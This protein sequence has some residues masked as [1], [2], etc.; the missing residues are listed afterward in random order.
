MVAL[1]TGIPRRGLGRPIEELAP[2]WLAQ[3]ESRLRARRGHARMRPEGAGPLH[4]LPLADR[5]I[6]TLFILRFTPGWQCST[7]CTCP[8]SPARWGDPAAA[9]RPLPAGRGFSLPGKPG[10]AAQPGRCVCPRRHQ[11]SE[12]VGSTA[13]R[14]RSAWTP[15]TR[16]WSGTSPSR[17]A[18]RRRNQARTPYP[19]KRP[20]GTSNATGSPPSGS[21]PGTPSPNPNNGGRC[22]AS[23][24]A[25]STS[26]RLPW[27]SP[28]S[29][30]TTPPRGNHSGP[31]RQADTAC[32]N[33]AA[34]R[35]SG[36]TPAAIQVTR[37]PGERFWRERKEPKPGRRQ[38]VRATP[39]FPWPQR[40]GCAVP[41]Q[42]S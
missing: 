3:R 41:E 2:A 7:G 40:R 27:P 11:R 31:T 14:C 32:P 4:D 37:R 26:Q 13:P 30:P 19:K 6:A 42:V 29:C 9:R 15:A 36:G 18:S 1:C 23:S 25:A 8:P 39:A 35:Y 28:P 12:A 17:S 21:A 22:S 5:V 20:A 16:A 33:R 34:T 38:Q 10:P 24:A